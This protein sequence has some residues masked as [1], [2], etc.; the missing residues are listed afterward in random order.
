MLIVVYAQRPARQSSPPVGASKVR[1]TAQVKVGGGSIMASV[2]SIV[3]GWIDSR[4]L[5]STSQAYQ[6]GPFQL[7]W[8]CGI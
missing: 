3:I 5:M 2:N 1:C 7:G 8:S 4:R 6:D